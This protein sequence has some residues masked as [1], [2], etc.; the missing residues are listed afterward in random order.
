MHMTFYV[1]TSIINRN[2]QDT[3]H[4]PD[5]RITLIC[6]TAGGGGWWGGEGCSYLQIV[7]YQRQK[8]IN[9]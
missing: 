4:V 6:I 7:S 9:L 1:I 2:R 5:I 3:K 8:W